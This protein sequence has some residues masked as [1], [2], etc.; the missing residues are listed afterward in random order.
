MAQVR[1]G[2]GGSNNSVNDNIF[3]RHSL[4]ES[5][6][7][8]F[9][10]P[11][12]GGYS[13]CV[14]GLKYSPPGCNTLYNCV[15]YAAGCFN[16]TVSSVKGPGWHYNLKN[17]A[18]R[19]LVD[20]HSIG[21]EIWRDKSSSLT[22]NT[23]SA[24]VI[25][26]P[27]HI[28]PVGSIMVWRSG[29]EGSGGDGVGHVAY[30]FESNVE[31]GY[32]KVSYSNTWSTPLFVPSITLYR[33]K[34]F[35]IN[36]SQ[37]YIGCIPNPVVPSNYKPTN[38][39][40]SS[41]T[42]GYDTVVNDGTTN[43]PAI[44]NVVF[45]DDHKYMSIVG[46]YYLIT[47]ST[48]LNV[49]IKNRVTLYYLFTNKNTGIDADY[50]INQQFGSN[51][52]GGFYNYPTNDT[53]ITG[54]LSSP[55][56]NLT[57][58][59]INIEFSNPT[60]Y[61]YIYCVLIEYDKD[62]DLFLQSNLYCPQFAPNV[63]S[64]SHYVEI[65]TGATTQDSISSIDGKTIENRWWKGIPYIYH[66]TGRKDDK[67]N[68][69]YQWYETI[70]YIYH[71]GIWR[72]IRTKNMNDNPTT[73]PIDLPALDRVPEYIITYLMNN[74]LTQAA[75]VG[76]CANVKAEC[77]YKIDSY[78]WDVNGYSGG[79]CQWHNSLLTTMSNYVQN[80]FHVDWRQSLEGQCSF[81]VQQLKTTTT[82]R[83]PKY[84]SAEA[85]KRLGLVKGEKLIDCLNR[86]ANTQI[87]A[88]DCAEIFV[89]LYEYPAQRDVAS[90]KRRG[91]AKD[92]WNQITAN[93]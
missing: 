76:V 24:K 30:V 59:D 1:N 2:A 25:V 75:A 53:F 40:Q 82:W 35:S 93:P 64:Y 55:K 23:S 16:E 51:E 86:M 90:K 22:P 84:C 71:N 38:N 29:A 27:S 26:N 73:T 19:F 32:V 66:N 87:G 14:T 39:S 44:N 78:G 52:S 3:I 89:R 91:F 56:G 17:R 61:K 92:I 36:S 48:S 62:S 58:N 74:G 28:P 63:P 6:N 83:V 50:V 68:P 60:N 4:P 7:K 46:T 69:I 57:I 20:A 34:N 9:N 77:G 18:E 10:S 37:I 88:E 80:N 5:G 70:P 43:G 65:Y 15:G 67:G 11:S 21:L 72:E 47:K 81:L 54:T 13:Q 42:S 33:N 85:V 31:K 12:K 8:F 49:K 79:I 41:D 45:S